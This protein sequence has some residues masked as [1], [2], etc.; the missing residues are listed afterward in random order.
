MNT[1]ARD[2]YAWATYGVFA[3]LGFVQASLG[4]I[5]P[6]LRNELGFSYAVGGLHLSTFALGAL[7][8]SLAAPRAV[9]VLDL[10]RVLWLSVCGMAGGCLLLAA[11]RSA[12][13]TLLAAGVIGVFTAWIVGAV[14][15]LLSARHGAN[16]T[17][18]L[19]EVDVAA[20]EGHHG[21]RAL[22]GACGLSLLLVRTDAGTGAVRPTRRRAGHRPDVP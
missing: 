14:Q 18:A 6:T 10:R 22:P 12:T 17:V 2:K 13:V 15:V 11:A 9:G 20:S 3:L 5:L 4:P 16:R 1:L 21:R 7:L 19:V 8:A